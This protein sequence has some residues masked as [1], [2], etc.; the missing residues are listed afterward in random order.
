MPRSPGSTRNHTAAKPEPATQSTLPKRIWRAGLPVS[1]HLPLVGLRISC[2]PNCA[3]P[4][5]P[6]I[7]A[8]PVASYITIAATMP[9]VQTATTANILPQNS[10]PKTG[11]NINPSAPRGRTAAVASAVIRAPRSGSRRQK[12]CLH[13]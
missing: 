13:T 11:S 7:K 12:A 8:D 9:C 2:G 3:T 10:A 5:S 4:T 6:T 1:A